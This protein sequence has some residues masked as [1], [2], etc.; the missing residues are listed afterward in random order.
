MHMDVYQRV[1][2][3]RNRSVPNSFSLHRLLLTKGLKK[4]Q[5]L[6]AKLRHMP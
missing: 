5:V 3:V 6:L 4:Y 1:L 2:Q